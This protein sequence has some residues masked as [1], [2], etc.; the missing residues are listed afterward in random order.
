MRLFIEFSRKVHWLFVYFLLAT[1]YFF[2]LQSAL[3]CSPARAK[4]FMEVR[5]DGAL[6]AEQE[7]CLDRGCLFR[8]VRKQEHGNGQER[9]WH[10][11]IGTEKE[12]SCPTTIATVN[13]NG[14]EIVQSYCFSS[15]EQ[16]AVPMDRAAFGEAFE[17]LIA[18][19][20]NEISPILFDEIDRYYG[21]FRFFLKGQMKITPYEA[22]KEQQLQRSRE[23][24][25]GCHYDDYKRAGNWLIIQRT[26]RSYCYLGPHSISCPITIISYPQFLS[27]LL[28]D[29]GGPTLPYLAALMILLG[30]TGLVLVSAIRR[31]EL[32]EFLLPRK[33]QLI[34]CLGL[35][36]ILFMTGY[37]LEDIPIRLGFVYLLAGLARYVH[38]RFVS[39]RE[40]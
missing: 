10:E 30:G 32:D 4:V 7:S 36:L 27:Y 11:I 38:L 37:G 15:L 33:G 18:D 1:F 22:I 19:D 31:N 23:Q 2:P 6:L 16:S 20:I 9:S 39:A 8:I 5:L 34:L 29:I 26:S 28:S 12:G 35:G 14:I 13:S 17:R 3:A 21:N 25:L 40:G 24:L